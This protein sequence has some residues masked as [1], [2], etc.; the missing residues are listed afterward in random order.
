MKKRIFSL[1]LAMVM[2]FT[3]SAVAVSAEDAVVEDVPVEDVPVEDVP[4]ATCINITKPSLPEYNVTSKVA[5]NFPSAEG[6]LIGTNSETFDPGI[7]V[8]SDEYAIVEGGS[9][10]ALEEGKATLTF[11]DVTVNSLLRLIV[12]TD[13]SVLPGANYITF[14]IDTTNLSGTA[15]FNLRLNNPWNAFQ[16]TNGAK[17]Y[18]LPDATEDNPSPKKVSFVVGDT[19][20]EG[21]TMPAGI[22]GTIYLPLTSFSGIST[23]DKFTEWDSITHKF[24]Q[25]T[26]IYLENK[27]EYDGGA[28]A[29]DSIVFSNLEWKKIEPTAA[30]NLGYNAEYLTNNFS[31]NETGKFDF[32]SSVTGNGWDNWQSPEIGGY[33]NETFDAIKFDLDYSEFTGNECYMSLR[34]IFNLT[35]DG[36]TT[37]H[38][39][40]VQNNFYVVWE[41]GKVQEL[42]P[43][44][45]WQ[46]GAIQFPSG[47]KGTVIIPFSCFVDV[48]GDGLMFTDTAEYPKM[49]MWFYRPTSSPAV[50]SVDNFGFLTTY[51]ATDLVSV[52]AQLMGETYEET[53]KTVDLNGDGVID[54]IDIVKLKKIVAWAA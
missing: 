30:A 23:F 47:F 53:E 48:N 18:F 34:Y 27:L 24:H 46:Q 26:A 1:L 31:K 12:K 3:L 16:L 25:N 22:I 17:Y 7:A 29:G 13:D 54:A 19:S 14:H 45:G 11:N 2:L 21:F 49:E 42:E 28:V 41:D 33:F 36:V 10:V 37:L 44:P 4:V 40:F 51:N 32:N 15:Y 38:R 50:A 6:S 52:R 9:T 39:Y 8:N 20:F 5:N 43:N 35:V